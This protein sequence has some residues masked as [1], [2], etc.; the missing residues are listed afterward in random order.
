MKN[1]EIF[2]AL[3]SVILAELYSSFP[4]PK[5]IKKSEIALQLHDEYWEQAYKQDPNNENV[6]DLV[7]YN[8][9]YALSGPTIE[10][11]S[12]AGLISYS[13]KTSSTYENVVLTAKGLE[14]IEVEAERGMN[15]LNNA[16][17]LA[18]D[19]FRDAAKEQLKMIASNIIKWCAEKSPT[20]LLSL[21]HLA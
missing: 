4:L 11:L 10:W 13:N 17:N 6:Y 12:N 20:I 14:S 7:N 21:H 8:S 16:A 15:L 5:S 3:T 9:P 2:K 1:I 19:A 18:Q